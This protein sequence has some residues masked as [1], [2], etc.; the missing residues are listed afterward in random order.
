M[1]I[2]HIHTSKAMIHICAV[3]ST[4]ARHPEAE[5][6]KRNMDRIERFGGAGTAVGPDI[7]FVV[8]CC[9][10]MCFQFTT[11]IGLLEDL[12]KYSL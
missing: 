3:L 5:G 2:I 8:L 11:T 12:S 1:S 6:V 10:S 4:L 7:L 9:M